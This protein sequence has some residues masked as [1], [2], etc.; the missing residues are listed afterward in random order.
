MLAISLSVFPSF[1]I[2]VRIISD[3][4]LLTSFVSGDVR[5]QLNVKPNV[6]VADDALMQ[7]CATFHCPCKM[8]AMLTREIS[9]L[10]VTGPDPRL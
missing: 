6:M 5:N 1:T 2:F 3:V 9:E 8:A 10:H 7:Q 4:L